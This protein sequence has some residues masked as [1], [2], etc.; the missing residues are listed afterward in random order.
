MKPFGKTLHRLNVRR[1]WKL[2]RQKTLLKQNAL[3]T[4]K[5]MYLKDLKDRTTLE[6]SLQY[7]K[8]KLIQVKFYKRTSK[9]PKQKAF[10]QKRQK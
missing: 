9:L 4:S 5:S 8:D 1:L 2:I 6:I 7:K 10:R 3:S